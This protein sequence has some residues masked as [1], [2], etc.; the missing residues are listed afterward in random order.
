MA[1][2]ES[3]MN[4]LQANLQPDTF[5]DYTPNGLQLEGSMEVTKLVG[6]TTASLPVIETCIQLRAN[7]L[8]V[9]H[10]W[11]WPSDPKPITG[12]WKKK[13]EMA[14]ECNLN[15][16]AYHLPLDC[17][18]SLGNN[19]PVLKKLNLE[20]IVAIEAPLFGG[21]FESPQNVDDLLNRLKDLFENCTFINCNSNKPVKKVAI[22]SGAGQTFFRQA[23]NWG[24]DFF[25]TGEGTEWVYSMA[26]ENQCHFAAVG[27][28][29]GERIGVQL[30]GAKLAQEFSL[31]FQFIKEDNPF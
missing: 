19:I 16:V 27:H 10:G 9:H 24:A 15:L 20:N 4:F 21:E 12:V 29:A 23:I 6:A 14:M 26:I 7:M 31:D 13:L 30:L 3:I 11:F 18:S 8:L 2:R 28:N 25:I 1:Q 5:K 17:H 22:C